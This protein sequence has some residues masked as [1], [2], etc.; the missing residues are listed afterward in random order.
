M[1]LNHKKSNGKS[2]L[3]L[4]ALL[5][6]LG[7]FMA[8]NAE[9]VTNYVYQHPQKKLAKKGKKAGKVNFSGKT[10]DV[11]ADTA[12]TAPTNIRIPGVAY[13]MKGD[14]ENPLFIIDGKRSSI[15]EMQTLDPKTIDHITV[16]KD[17]ASIDLYGEE[18]KNGVILIT[19]K[20]AVSPG[21]S[22]ATGIFYPKV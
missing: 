4:L 19:T 20:N 2:W 1:M 17:K 10:I 22:T 3:K 7:V 16:L 6:I 15:E 8:L 14:M 18:G 12:A 5:P 21:D 11:K 13:E 9:T